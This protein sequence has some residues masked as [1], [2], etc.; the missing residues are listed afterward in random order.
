MTAP[1]LFVI[2]VQERLFSAMPEADRLGLLKSIPALITLAGHERWD[3]WVSEQYPKGLGSTIPEI[4]AIL[5]P[6]SSAVEKTEFDATLNQELSRRL[7][8]L[9]RNTPF[10]IVGIE[11]HICVYL[12]AVSLKRLG[13]PVTVLSGTVASRN[14]YDRDQ[15]LMALRSQGVLVIPY[16]TALFGSLKTSTHR[17]FREMS[18][19]VR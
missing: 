14:P 6:N 16:E 18:Q 15:A 4:R 5:P 11:A 10:M 1:I 3:V 2:D 12:T 8:A 17:A 13:F 19:M 9:T 7:K